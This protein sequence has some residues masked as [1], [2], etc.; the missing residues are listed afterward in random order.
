MLFCKKDCTVHLCWVAFAEGGEVEYFSSNSS[1]RSRYSIGGSSSGITEWE[2]S[3]AQT[4]I[5]MNWSSAG[6]SSVVS[7]GSEKSSVKGAETIYF[8][9]FFDGGYG[10][11]SMSIPEYSVT[12]TISPRPGRCLAWSGSHYKTFD[13]KLYRYNNN[14]SIL[15]SYLFLPSF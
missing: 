6:R 3:G 7:K 13:G 10:A 9:Q 2:N 12:R 15:N 11:E 1:K 14:Y 8:E 4:G 5:E